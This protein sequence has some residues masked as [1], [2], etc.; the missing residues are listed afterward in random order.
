M[1]LLLLNDKTNSAYSQNLFCNLSY[2]LGFKHYKYSQ[3]CFIIL[4]WKIL[5]TQ[6]DD[7]FIAW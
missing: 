7:W 3:K 6:D 1:S 4:G 5:W 2:F